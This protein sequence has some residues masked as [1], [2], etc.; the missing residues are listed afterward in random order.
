MNMTSGNTVHRSLCI[1][2]AL[3]FILAPA[4]CAQA[5]PACAG[6]QHFNHVTGTFK[7]V[8]SVSVT[9]QAKGIVIQYTVQQS[10]AGSVDLRGNTGTSLNGTNAQTWTVQEQYN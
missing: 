6:W 2:I 7:V 3:G 10:Y 5:N 9:I 1:G 8:A 4:M